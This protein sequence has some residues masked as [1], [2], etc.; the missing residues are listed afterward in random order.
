MEVCIRLSKPG[1]FPDDSIELHKVHQQ[2]GSGTGSSVGLRHGS[3]MQEVWGSNSTLGGLRASPLQASA[4]IGTQQSRASGLR[5]T[6]QGIPSGPN[7]LLRVNKRQQ[8]V[9]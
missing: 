7:R 9:C 4:G 5:S 8:I 2:L 1:H 6:M 3:Q